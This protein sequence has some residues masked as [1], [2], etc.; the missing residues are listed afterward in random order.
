MKTV[1]PSSDSQLSFQPKSSKSTFSLQSGPHSQGF[2][3]PV[4]HASLPLIG[5]KFFFFIH[6]FN[7]SFIFNSVSSFLVQ[8]SSLYI[9]T[10]TMSNKMNLIE[11]KA[12]ELYTMFRVTSPRVIKGFELLASLHIPHYIPDIPKSTLA[13]I[14][15]FLENFATD[16]DLELLQ[17]ILPPNLITDIFF[18]LE[19]LE[20]TLD[21]ADYIPDFFTHTYCKTL[22]F[23]SASCFALHGTSNYPKSTL[24]KRIIFRAQ[25]ADRLSI[26]TFR[27]PEQSEITRKPFRLPPPKKPHTR[28]H[29][30]TKYKEIVVN[31]IR[32]FFPI[33]LM[34]CCICTL[35]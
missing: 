29:T 18:Q 21:Q 20:E 12:P 30:F 10:R 24:L 25:Y 11:I 16:T 14:Y 27:N 22:Q 15:N 34:P 2:R 3:L 23:Q 6:F 33:P 31:F 28:T 26:H 35:S 4:A 13:T 8:S 1:T 19:E 7:H 32:A 17:H 5:R 9:H